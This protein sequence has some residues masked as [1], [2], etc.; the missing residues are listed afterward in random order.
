MKKKGVVDFYCLF[1]NKFRFYS[2]DFLLIF[3]DLK[4]IENKKE[5]DLILV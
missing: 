3:L 2:F 4:N 1:L 5:Y